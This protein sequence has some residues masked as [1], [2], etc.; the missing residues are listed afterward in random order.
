MM[1]SIRWMEA[2]I[3]SSSCPK[4][5]NLIWFHRQIHKYL[6]SVPD[7]LI[8]IHTPTFY[9]YIFKAAMD[10]IFIMLY[11]GLPVQFKLQIY[12]GI[13]GI[14]ATVSACMSVLH[15]SIFPLFPIPHPCNRSQIRGDSWKDFWKRKFCIAKSVS[16]A[17][18]SPFS[19]GNWV[20]WHILAIILHNVVLLHGPYFL[21][22]LQSSVASGSWVDMTAAIPGVAFSNF[23]CHFLFVAWGKDVSNTTTRGLS[24]WINV[25]VSVFW[26]ATLI[27][28][29]YELKSFIYVSLVTWGL[30]FM[31]LVFH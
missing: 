16:L 12:K 18:T 5:H 2:I 28:T 10:S 7:R 29:L 31:Y 20:R 9:S 30:F 11:D 6:L 22:S 17:N 25:W 8:I 3:I 23:P 14:H 24:L 15:L 21:T 19:P 27:Q 26:L 4:E 13:L 1:F